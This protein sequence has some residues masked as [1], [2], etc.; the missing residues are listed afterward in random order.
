[1]YVAWLA[2]DDALLFLGE[3]L[4]ANAY[5]QPSLT[6][7][8]PDGSAD[9]DSSSQ[10]RS[11]DEQSMAACALAQHREKASTKYCD[12]SGEMW[13]DTVRHRIECALRKSKDRRDYSLPSFGDGE[14]SAD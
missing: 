14:Q 5:V 1:V 4:T 8:D 3:T 9:G 12:E 7:D 6:S 13:Q 10:S 2:Q 11:K